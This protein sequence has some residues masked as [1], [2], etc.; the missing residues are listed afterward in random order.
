MRVIRSWVVAAMLAGALWLGGAAQAA[1]PAPEEEVLVTIR[2]RQ[3]LP[4]T[5][6]LHAG[7]K[8]K[9]VFRNQDAE[10]HAFV[11]FTLFAG[12]NLNV[13]GNGAPEF[14]DDG[15]RRIIL[16]P[17]GHAEFRFVLDRPGRYPY[18]CDMPGHEMRAA[19][20]VE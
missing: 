5:I 2:G 10:L 3:F 14:G 4:D 6:T 17:D 8:T 9:L 20:I 15:F 16:P 18:I 11:P 19:I 1:P 7:R 12:V 13:G